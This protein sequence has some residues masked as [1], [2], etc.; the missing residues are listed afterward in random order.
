MQTES[1][2]LSK[3]LKEARGRREAAEDDIAK[4][5][6]EMAKLDMLAPIEQFTIS[7]HEK[8]CCGNH[9]SG[10]VWL[11]EIRNGIHDWTRSVHIQWLN[12]ARWINGEMTELGFFDG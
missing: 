2:K 12:H 9:S 6:A 8:F 7:L 10:C 3:L 4:I 1:E 11:Y 5:D